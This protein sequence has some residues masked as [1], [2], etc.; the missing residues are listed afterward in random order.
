[1]NSLSVGGVPPYLDDWASFLALVDQLATCGLIE[2][3]KDLWWDVRPNP[4]L[5]TVEVRI[6]DMPLGLDAV[7]GLTALIECLV[8]VLSREKMPAISGSGAM[9]SFGADVSHGMILQQNR[10]LASRY[11]MDAML[12]DPTTRQRV[13]ARTLARELIDRLVPVG[14]E[15]D[16]AEYLNMLRTRSRGPT[17]ADTQLATYSGT[18]ALTDVVRLMIRPDTSGHWHQWVSLGLDDSPLLNRTEATT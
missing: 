3:P 17:G 16:C 2:S 1:M 9:E 7:L 10:W 15:L 12:V 18:N 4:V 14:R 13:P 5:G 6:C 8:R 11:G